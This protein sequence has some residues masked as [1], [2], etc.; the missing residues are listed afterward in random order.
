MTK[1]DITE[2]QK[3]MLDLI[4][5]SPDRGDGWRSV[6]PALWKHVVAQAHSKLTELDHEGHRV[7]FTADGEILMTYRFT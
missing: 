4:Y 5:R 3:I 1:I 2:E 6:S 7:R